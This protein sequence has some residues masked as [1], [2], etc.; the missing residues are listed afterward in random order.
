MWSEAVS[1]RHVL[2]VQRKQSNSVIQQADS[3]RRDAAS[4]L[5]FVWVW[6]LE[7]GWGLVWKRSGLSEVW[8]GVIS[9]LLFYQNLQCQLLGRL[10]INDQSK[11]CRIWFFFFFLLLKFELVLIQISFF[12]TQEEQ[13][14][15]AALTSLSFL[16]TPLEIWQSGFPFCVCLLFNAC[17]G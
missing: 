16:I 9:R 2:A 5:L 3:Q 4:G 15:F 8:T 13:Q 14:G 1:W 12:L 6:G 11:R 7:T 17:T 10:H